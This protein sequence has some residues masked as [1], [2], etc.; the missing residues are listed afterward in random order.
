MQRRQR[1][2]LN[3]NFATSRHFQGGQPII[4]RSK[5]IFEKDQLEAKQKVIA[6]IFP[7]INLHDES[8]S[9]P[10][11]HYKRYNVHVRSGV[12]WKDSDDPV[13]LRLTK[14]TTQSIDAGESISR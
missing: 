6:S 1:R 3:V 7:G 2:Q 10:C 11:K 12:E 13:L 5:R 14:S 4:K 8:K 9:A